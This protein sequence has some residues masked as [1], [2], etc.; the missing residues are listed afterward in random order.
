LARFH[1]EDAHAWAEAMADETKAES[2]VKLQF[3]YIKGQAYKEVLCDGAIGGATPQGKI[4]MAL[5]AERLPIPRLV[6][7]EVVGKLGE[8]INFSETDSKPIF[9][10]SRHGIIRHIEVTAY[11]DLEVAKRIHDW[12][13]KHITVL[14]K[15]KKSST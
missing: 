9:T 5:Y 2:K 7:Y 14:E 1:E 11:M 6:E 4:W 3:N 8:K 10:D 13:G 12:L 15:D